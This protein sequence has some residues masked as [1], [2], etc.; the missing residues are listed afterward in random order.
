MQTTI[1]TRTLAVALIAVSALMLTIAPLPAQT[2][3]P[4]RLYDALPEPFAMNPLCHGLV[5][6]QHRAKQCCVSVLHDR[7]GQ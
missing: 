7:N 1:S 5:P 2:I 4:S 6:Q 3:G